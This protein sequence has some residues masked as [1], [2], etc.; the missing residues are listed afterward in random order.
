MHVEKVV[1]VE[2]FE[3]LADLY[4]LIDSG[5]VEAAVCACIVSVAGGVAEDECDFFVGA[6]T[7]ENVVHG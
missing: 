3:L 4:G 1:D 7:V 2:F 5:L 6:E